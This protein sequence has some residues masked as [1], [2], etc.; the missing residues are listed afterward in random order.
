[1][2]GGDA[3]N[4]PTTAYIP[5]GVLVGKTKYSY[6]YETVATDPDGNKV[7]YTFD[8]GDGTTTTTGYVPSGTW[9]SAAH[10]WTVE[11]GKSKGFD[12]TAK[13]TD[14][15]G[16]EGP[17]SI[18]MH[19]IMRAESAANRPPTIPSVSGPSNGVSGKP[20]EFSFVSTDPDGHY[21]EY[22]IYWGD[23]M[24][25]T[26]YFPSG[27]AVTASHS[28]KLPA[29]VLTRDY[30]IIATAIDICNMQCSPLWSSPLIITIADP[31][32]K[33]QK[34]GLE[35][36][37]NETIYVQ[38]EELEFLDAQT[39]E[40]ESIDVQTQENE[41]IDVQTEENESIDVQTEENES[42]DAQTQENESIDEQ[43]AEDESIDAQTAE[44]ES[45]DAQTAEDESIDAQTAEDESID[46]QTAENESIDEQTEE[47]DSVDA[48]TA[49]NKSIDEQTASPTRWQTE[50][51]N[52]TELQ[53]PSS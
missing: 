24:T 45:I 22:V 20:Y 33:V 10:Q 42:I 31:S 5:I 47:A 23:G 32:V 52:L 40:N 30:R 43:T 4:P 17:W 12:I 28:W 25:E 34:L 3:N 18:P 19:V 38:T 14:E 13:A 44:D 7:K 36:E 15:Y 29:G 11:P 53:S 8:W 41:S 37:G 2:G 49:E 48:Q 21:I 51:A 46:E 39:Q 26:G 16:K 9:A 6:P 35:A 27:Q 50:I 1:V